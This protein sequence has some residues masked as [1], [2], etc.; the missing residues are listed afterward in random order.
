M[1]SRGRNDPVVGPHKEKVQVLH[2]GCGWSHGELHSWWT[3]HHSL[4]ALCLNIG[5]ELRQ[6][7]KNNNNNNTVFT[8]VFLKCI[9]YQWYVWCLVVFISFFFF[10][11]VNKSFK[12]AVFQNVVIFRFYSRS[13]E[14]I[15][16]RY[17]LL[18]ISRSDVV[19]ASLWTTK[20]DRP[21]QRVCEIIRAKSTL[22][23]KLSLRSMEAHVRQHSAPR[24]SGGGCDVSKAVSGNF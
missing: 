21:V 11:L 2:W 14:R 13:K 18:F 24:S 8:Q 16:L 1:W 3:S 15:K 22:I 4:C 23:L 7:L 19:S 10:L 6:I 17:T 5:R 12:K 9:S 20:L